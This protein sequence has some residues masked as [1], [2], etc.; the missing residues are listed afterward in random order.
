MARLPKGSLPW[1]QKSAT[2]TIMSRLYAVHTLIPSF[3]KIHFNTNLQPMI[4]TLRLQLK[5]MYTVISLSA[6]CPAHLMIPDLS[7]LTV[8]GEIT[9]YEAPC[10]VGYFSLSSCCFLSLG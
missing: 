3:C 6:T 9:N 4:F 5:N 10:Y 1:S 8:F 2:W 7:T